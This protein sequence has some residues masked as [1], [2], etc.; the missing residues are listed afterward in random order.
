MFSAGDQC[1]RKFDVSLLT[2]GGTIIYHFREQGHFQ[3]FQPTFYR[4]IGYKDDFTTHTGYSLKYFCGVKPYDDSRR[5]ICLNRYAGRLR[6][7]STSSQDFR[8]LSQ[9]VVFSIE[10]QA[11]A[12]INNTLMLDRCLFD[13]RL[14]APMT[15]STMLP[16]LSTSFS[17]STSS[18]VTHTQATTTAHSLKT[19]P[20][21]SIITSSSSVTTPKPLTTAWLISSTS[22][23]GYYPTSTPI[24]TMITTTKPSGSPTFKGK[25]F[26]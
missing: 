25:N 8:N 6:V 2:P 14:T 20:H 12:T 3:R 5:F 18:S 22:Y 10:I 11:E 19:A 1:Y 21:S 23:I 13:I 17:P 16:V 7:R 24:T 4:V 15:T 9:G 26:L